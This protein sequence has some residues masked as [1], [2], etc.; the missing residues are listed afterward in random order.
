MQDVLGLDGSHRMNF[1]GKPEGNWSWRFAWADVPND[2]TTRLR[3]LNQLY[4]RH[5]DGRH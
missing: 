4:Q 5:G 1:P 2:T 3:R